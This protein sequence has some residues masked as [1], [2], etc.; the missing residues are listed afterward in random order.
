MQSAQINNGEPRVLIGDEQKVY[1]VAGALC[2]LQLFK[3]RFEGA[4]AFLAF[5]FRRGD[6][7]R[8]KFDEALSANSDKVAAII[9][10]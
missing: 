10:K 4:N 3:H 1:A 9:N 2:N 7:L 8:D 6:A 5:P